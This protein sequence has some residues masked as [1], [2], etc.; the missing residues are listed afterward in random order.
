[1]EN[2]LQN[3]CMDD[4]KAVLFDLDGTIYYGNKLIDGADSVVEKFRQKGKRVFFMTNNSAKNRNEIYEKLCGMGLRCFENEV[5]TSGYAAALYAKKQGFKN[6]YV[7]GT[8]GLKCEFVKMGLDVCNYAD[9]MIIGYDKEFDYGKLTAALG[10]ALNAAVII[11]CNREKNYPGEGAKRMPGCGAMVG[12]VEGS[13][14][15]KVDYCVGKP[16]P[17]LLEIICGQ[18]GL[19]SEEIMVVGDTYESDIEMASAYGCKS[20]FI[21]EDE[22]EDTITVENIRE[23][24][25]LWE[26]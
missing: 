14:G 21:G 17:L 12:A 25:R 9:A 8:E 24:D 10:V 3:Y 20:V 23:V 4:I 2:R 5:Y 11:A 15:R 7:C 6:V 26:K 18:Q 1:M 13:I 19:K 16:N 22:H